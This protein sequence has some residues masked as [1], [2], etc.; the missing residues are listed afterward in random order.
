MDDWNAEMNISTPKPYMGPPTL[1]Y[2][3]K[4]EPLSELFVRGI[5]RLET[6]KFIDKLGN[7][8]QKSRFELGQLLMSLHTLPKYRFLPQEVFVKLK[9]CQSMLYHRYQNSDSLL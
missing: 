9:L 3:R 4:G 6:L 1:G 2:N 7:Y 8:T 5:L